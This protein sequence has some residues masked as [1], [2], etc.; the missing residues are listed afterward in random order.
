MVGYEGYVL[1]ARRVS[2]GLAGFGGVAAAFGGQE[3]AFQPCHDRKN[4]L[5]A[6]APPPADR[7]MNRRG[8]TLGHVPRKGTRSAFRMFR[9]LSQGTDHEAFLVLP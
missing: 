5:R 8:G 9:D 2:L 6:V 4:R 7:P 1:T 3:R